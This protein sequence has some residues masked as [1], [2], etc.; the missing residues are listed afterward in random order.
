MDW[1]SRQAV[2]KGEAT[3]MTASIKAL[4]LMMSLCVSVTLAASEV[5]VE[6]QV[7]DLSSPIFINGILLR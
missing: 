5:D 2:R 7:N 1:A 6:M 3:S 4:I